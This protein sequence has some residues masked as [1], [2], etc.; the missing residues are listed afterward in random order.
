MRPKQWTKNGVVFAAFMF[1]L[2]DANQQVPLSAGWVVLLAVLAFCLASS[3]IYLINDVRDAEADR[4]HP[5]KRNRPIASG[6][7]PPRLA[8]AVAIQ[9]LTAALI[10]SVVLR[11]AFAAV[12]GAYILLQILYTLWL[13]H[14]AMIDVFVIATGFVLRADGGAVVIHVFVS[15]WLL[16]CAF[17]LAMF[18]GL[19]KRRQEY[20]RTDSDVE[21]ITRTSLRHYDEKLLD[22]L[23]GIVA[24][25][26]LVCYAIYTLAPET[27]EKFGHSR[28]IYSLVFVMFGLFRYLHL[29]YRRD[30]GERPEHVLLTDIP[31]L[32][33]LALYAAT[34]M[35]LLYA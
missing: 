33:D 13:K 19:C 27:V 2:G 22:Q 30:L 5:Q 16:V 11:P 26:T 28:L 18:L 31:L 23:I 24:S 8:I 15:P 35:V 10:L 3:G 25:A 9:L 32:A 20:V 1:A 14:L 17:L 12:I 34:V 6:R 7:V 4:A 29:V 21:R